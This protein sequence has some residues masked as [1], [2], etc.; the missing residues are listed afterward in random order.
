MNYKHLRDLRLKWRYRRSLR[1]LSIELLWT[2]TLQRLIVQD[3]VIYYV[4]NDIYI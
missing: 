3:I 1:S 4:K 2:H